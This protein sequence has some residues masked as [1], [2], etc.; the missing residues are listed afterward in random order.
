LTDNGRLDESRLDDLITERTKLV[1]IVHMSNIL[2]TVNATA[3]IPARVR[4]VGALLML[5]CSQSVP[6]LP[7]DVRDLDADFIA[8]TGHK[9]LG[10]TGIGVVWGRRP[11]LDAMPPFLGGGSMIETVT[12][13]RT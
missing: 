9:M 1:S 11:L 10:P 13:E 4:E 3:R 5:D 2:G 6:H 8:F 7:V 12:M